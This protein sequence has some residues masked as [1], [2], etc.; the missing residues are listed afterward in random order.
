MKDLK[1]SQKEEDKLYLISSIPSILICLAFAMLYTF[2]VKEIYQQGFQFDYILW[3]MIPYFLMLPITASF[4]F[5]LAY[6]VLYHRKIKEP[7]NFHIKRLTGRIT[8]VIFGAT[9]FVLI[10]TAFLTFLLPLTSPA[11]T[12][13]AISLVW[14]L[15]FFMLM[16]KF[17]ETFSKFEKGEW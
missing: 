1:I 7:L 2:R 12:L 16:K 10:Y 6:E 8:T 4:S 15:L 17:K 9:S 5:L 14:S 13:F 11:I 3:D